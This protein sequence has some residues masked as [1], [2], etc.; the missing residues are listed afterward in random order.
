MKKYEVQDHIPSY[1]PE[2]SEWKL[3]WSDEFDGTELDRTKWDFRLIFWGERFDAYTDQG[4][5]SQHLGDS[6]C[7]NKDTHIFTAG[8]KAD[9]LLQ[10][11]HGHIESSNAYHHCQQTAQNHGVWPVLPD[12]PEKNLLQNKHSVG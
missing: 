1:L 9:K 7:I 4:G 2:D 10:N 11:P 12:N 8:P 5:F 3:V 6:F